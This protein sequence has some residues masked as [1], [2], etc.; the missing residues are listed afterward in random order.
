MNVKELIKKLK[1]MPPDSEVVWQD[2]DH[3]EYEVNA[4]VR[5][6]G[7]TDFDNKPTSDA[8]GP[9]AHIYDGYDWKGKIVCLRP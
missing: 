3:G 1:Q 5:Y 7:L 4:R 2:H 8:R 6:V 9:Y